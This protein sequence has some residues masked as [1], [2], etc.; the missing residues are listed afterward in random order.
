MSNSSTLATPCTTVLQLF[1]EVV[2]LEVLRVRSV[3]PKL[4]GEGHQ[5]AYF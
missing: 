4:G 1:E 2:K 5:G 3:Q